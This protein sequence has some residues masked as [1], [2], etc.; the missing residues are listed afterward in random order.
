[1]II[2]SEGATNSNEPPD[3]PTTKDYNMFV[4]PHGTSGMVPYMDVYD[5]DPSGDSGT[6]YVDEVQLVKHTA[7]STGWSSMT[8][9]T[10]G[11]WTALTSIPPY[12]SVSSG[13]VSGLQLT[14]G[15]SSSFNFGFWMSP[16]TMSYSAATLYRATFDVSSS[17]SNPPNGMFRV[18]S[19]DSQMSYRLKYYAAL[20]PDA[21]GEDYTVYFETH[22]YEVAYP[23]F[24]LN[25]EIGDFEPTQGGTLSLDT[26]T[27]ES[28]G[29][30]F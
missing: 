6:V 11:S 26:V 5:F 1:M 17:D 18:S 2:Q 27:V 24:N 16:S 28:H 4:W 13:Q 19:E 29:F 22:D 15:I 20:A 7:P 14:S 21:D 9:P 12:G 23:N 25:F 3:Y 10:F 8:V 30:P